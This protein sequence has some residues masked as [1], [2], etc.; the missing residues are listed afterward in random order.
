MNGEVSAIGSAFLWALSSAM[1]RGL[2]TEVPSLALNALRSVVGVLT[3]G[4][5]ILVD[6]RLG[7]F[8]D[9]RPQNLLFLTIN[10]GVGILLGDTIYYSSMRLVGVSRALT[11]S[12]IYPLLTT[13]LAG[14]FLGEMF[15]PETYVGF[16]L[17]VG[18]VILVARSGLGDKDSSTAIAG[19]RGVA[20]ALMAAVC[21]SV[22]TV[23]LRQGSV[24]MDPYIVNFMRMGGV[25]L[26]AGVWARARGEFRSIRRLSMGKVAMLVAGA[27]IGSVIGSVFYLSAVQTAGASKAAVLASTAPLFSVPMSLLTGERMNAKLLGGMAAAIAGVV[28]VVS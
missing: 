10:L 27:I 20:F 15:G 26:A 16:V 21:W 8:A 14:L 5:V 7:A 13:V 11:V 4:V 9:L 18:G 3:Y 1:L 17:C 12:S 24:D 6:G 28:I 19:G 2:T 25:A 22:G 23:S